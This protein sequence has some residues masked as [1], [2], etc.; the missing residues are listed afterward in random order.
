MPANCTFASNRPDLN[1]MP[2]EILDDPCPTKRAQFLW[3]EGVDYVS[4][5]HTII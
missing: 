4:G 3:P 1:I 2:Q 5:A